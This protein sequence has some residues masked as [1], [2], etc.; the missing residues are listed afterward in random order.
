MS[1]LALRRCGLLFDDLLLGALD[2]LASPPLAQTTPPS[3]ESLQASQ[4]RK[5]L[6]VQRVGLYA[7]R[8]EAPPDGR[9]AGLNADSLALEEECGVREL[10]LQVWV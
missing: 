7:Q 2:H 8:A 10:R 1:K 6:D 9:V 4:G 5:A 3:A